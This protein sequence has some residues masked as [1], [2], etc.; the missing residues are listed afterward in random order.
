MHYDIS[1]DTDKLRFIV[2]AREPVDLQQVDAMFRDIVSHQCWACQ[3]DILLDYSAS[4]LDHLHPSDI[5]SMADMIR[6]YSELIGPVK[7]AIVLNG[8]V[9]FGMGRMW[10]AYA[11][12]HMPCETG[13]FRNLREADTWLQ[14][15]E[16]TRLQSSY[17]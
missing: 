15:S 3:H 10:Q 14:I 17:R 7:L 2:R 9:N 6:E 11:S 5:I 16:L 13:I 1:V 12:Y 8:D 4:S